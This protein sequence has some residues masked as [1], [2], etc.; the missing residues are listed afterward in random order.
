[1]SIFLSSPSQ[2]IE[3]W[4][5][6]SGNRLGGLWFMSSNSALFVH[7][8]ESGKP[9]KKK[10]YL[11][12]LIATCQVFTKLQT[13]P[14]QAQ[15]GHFG[16]TLCA[17]FFLESHHITYGEKYCCLFFV[18][19]FC[20]FSLGFHDT[21]MHTVTHVVAQICNGRAPLRPSFPKLK[22]IPRA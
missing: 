8:I 11:Q 3:V 16:R 2:N 1:M 7:H 4:K 10:K 13:S 15:H 6:S 18:G 17:Y 20:G 9:E 14:I 5:P 21:K 19:L 12:V 22:V